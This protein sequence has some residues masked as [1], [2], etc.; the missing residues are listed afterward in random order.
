MGIFTVSP[1]RARIEQ[2]EREARGSEQS[3]LKRKIAAVRSAIDENARHAVPLADERKKLQAIADP[4]PAATTQH[5]AFMGSV[6][7]KCDELRAAVKRCESDLNMAQA[8]TGIHNDAQREALQA[9]LDEIIARG[10]ALA[11][12]IDRETLARLEL[13]RARTKLDEFTEGTS[14]NTAKTK[15][16]LDAAVAEQ[17]QR[18]RRIAA[19]DAEL[20]RIQSFR[21]DELAQLTSELAQHVK[22]H[23]HLA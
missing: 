21:Q 3:A 6:N 20:A 9:E 1:E 4:V 12:R 10:N 22:K 15:A 18:E 23:G 2:L 13:Q 16:A 7:A 5:D 8:E 11:A 19:I 14:K 17:D